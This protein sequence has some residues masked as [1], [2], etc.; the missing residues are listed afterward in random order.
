MRRIQACCFAVAAAMGISAVS[1]AAAAESPAGI[2]A[3]RAYEGT[4]TISLQFFETPYSKASTEKN[5][6]RNECWKNGGYFACHQYVDG[7]SKVLLVFTFDQGKNEYTSYQI[8]VGGAS[9]GSGKLFI[10]GNRWT[11]PWQ[12]GQGTN[13]TYFRVVNTFTTPDRIEF[14]QEYS[15]D[16][17]H[18]TLM[19]QGSE[20]KRAAK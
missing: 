11:Y 3:I 15:S 1:W 20:T 19:A 18:W 4:W 8:P 7:Q 5:T 2:D 9:P 14:R 6:L 13:T 10:E 16:Q 17:A 12:T